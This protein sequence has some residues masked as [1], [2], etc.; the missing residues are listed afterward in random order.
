MTVEE[1]AKAYSSLESRFGSFTGAPKD[2]KYAEYK[3]PENLGVEL[4]SDHPLLADFDKW[5]ATKQLNQEGR[6]ELLTMLMQYEAS[7]LPD[8]N[9]QKALLGPNADARLT[10]VDAWGR[11]NL[12][13]TGYATLRSAASGHQAAAVFQIVETLIGKSNQAAL[14]KPGADIPPPPAT[15]N[16]AYSAAMKQ[17]DANG[18]LLYFTDPQHR[19]KT[20]AM[21]NS[22]AAAAIAQ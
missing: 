16:E 13:A 10:A 14:P 18:Q 2:G 5:A 1:Q 21:A 19:L 3:A 6:N 11:A 20:E 17:K 9:A 15:T 4:V 22:I 8:A 12:D 7:N